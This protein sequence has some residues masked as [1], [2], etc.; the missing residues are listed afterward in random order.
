MKKRTIFTFFCILLVLSGCRKGLEQAEHCLPKPEPPAAEETTAESEEEPEEVLP[1]ESS[2]KP[3]Q[4]S[5]A[6]DLGT[7]KEL[8][9]VL[10]TL[11]TLEDWKSSPEYEMITAQKEKVLSQLIRSFYHGQDSL[12]LRDTA[13]GDRDLPGMA[14]EVFRSLLGSEDLEREAE[15][16]LEWFRTWFIWAFGHIHEADAE[17]LQAQYPASYA[18]IY[19]LMDHHDTWEN[20]VTANL[21]RVGQYDFDLYA[22]RDQIVSYIRKN[23]E[24]WPFSYT[25]ILRASSAPYG[26]ERQTPGDPNLYVDF[27]WWAAYT[28]SGERTEFLVQE[29]TLNPETGESSVWTIPREDLGEE[30]WFQ[31]FPDWVVDTLFDGTYL[32]SAKNAPPEIVQP[33]TEQP[34]NV[35]PGSEPAQSAA[36]AATMPQTEQ[37]A[38]RFAQAEG[39]LRAALQQSTGEGTEDLAALFWAYDGQNGNLFGELPAFSAEAIATQPMDDETWD[40]LS[41]F[42]YERYARENGWPLMIGAEALR[43]TFASYFP[44]DSSTW[45]DRSSHYLTYQDGIYTRTVYDDGHHSR[46]CYLRGVQCKQDGSIEL[47]FDSLELPAD[48]EYKTADA[49]IRAVFDYAGATELQ[50]PAFREAVWQA[51]S[52]GVLPL[53][54]NN[55]GRIVTLCLTGDAAQPFRFLACS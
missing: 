1:E 4:E 55:T 43:D 38:A 5:V 47:R 10:Q 3:K 2:A 49:S 39:K 54:G 26:A 52:A 48:M 18:A 20:S 31:H 41:L 15:T 19:S 44:L 35:Q 13:W 25:L 50:P 45:Q 22:A 36:A 12:S 16:P 11:Q 24:I 51:F 14:F 9:E 8:L 17:G 23:E 32:S 6:P 29:L 30:L 42:A 7:Y 21:D 37:D 40:A 33:E 53:E 27:I 46:Y 28:A 34:E